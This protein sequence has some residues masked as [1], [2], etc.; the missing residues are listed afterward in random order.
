MLV[1]SMAPQ[2]IAVDE[3]GSREDVEAMEYVMH[4]G[5]KLIATAHGSS[6]A[7]IRRKPVLCRMV[8]EQ[9]F[10]RYI[11]LQKK[12]P[13]HLQAVLDER[14]RFLFRAGQGREWGTG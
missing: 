12:Q 11:I 3:V 4:S 7:D 14:E 8:K 10:R 6:L 5:V 9:Q 13:G 1:R 2:V